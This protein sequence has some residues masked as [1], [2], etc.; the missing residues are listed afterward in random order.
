[1]NVLAA[2]ILG[3]VAGVIVGIL[4]GSALGRH[5]DRGLM[6]WWLGVQL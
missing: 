3:L 2:G 1:M 6:P 4:A 5:H